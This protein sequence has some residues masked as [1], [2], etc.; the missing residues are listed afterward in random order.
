MDVQQQLDD[1][2][3]RIRA[4]EKNYSETKFSLINVEKSQS[5][6]KLLV[7]ESNARLDKL[8]NKFVDSDIQAKKTTQKNIWSLVFKIW[9]VIAPAV[10]ILFSCKK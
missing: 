6:L 3:I 7:T 4:L 2:E 1:H 10:A 9:I 5:D 8:L